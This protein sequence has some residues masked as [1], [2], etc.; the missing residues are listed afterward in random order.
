[1]HIIMGLIT[2]ILSLLLLIYRVQVR[3]FMGQIGWAEHYF[4]PGGTYTAL[5][6]F[7]IFGFFFSLMLMT[8]TLGNI[9]GGFLG[10]FFNSVN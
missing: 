6:L 7:G 8:G 3:R 2:A 9:F 4:G 10:V 1:M 5:L